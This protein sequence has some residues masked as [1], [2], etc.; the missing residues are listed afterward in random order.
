MRPFSAGRYSTMPHGVDVLHTKPTRLVYNFKSRVTT[1]WYFDSPDV[2]VA[3]AV[4]VLK[5]LVQM[6]TQQI[7]GP[8]PRIDQPDSSHSSLSI[9]SRLAY[10]LDAIRHPKA[11]ACVIWLVGQYAPDTN[12]SL[13][14]NVDSAVPEDMN[15]W[16]PDVLRKSAKSFMQ[17]V[18]NSLLEC[19][20]NANNISR[21]QLSSYRF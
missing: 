1:Y 19:S 18:R 2:I 15:S 17:E 4:L 16:A 7:G 6:R 12:P 9:I 13:H 3:H 11:R 20:L 5:S 21:H 14:N 8:L 10:K